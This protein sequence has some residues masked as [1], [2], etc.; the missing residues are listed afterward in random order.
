MNPATDS[1]KKPLPPNLHEKFT[2]INLSD[3]FRSDI[4]MM[5]STL[6]PQLNST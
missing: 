4:E 5:I 2:T 1:G 3:P 6:C